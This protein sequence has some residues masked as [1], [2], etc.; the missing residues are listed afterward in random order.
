MFSNDPDRGLETLV[1]RAFVKV[2]IDISPEYVI[3]EGNE[4]QVLTQ[5]V[6]ITAQGE[7]PLK[8]EPMPFALAEKV[9]YRLEVIEPG[10]VF[11]ILF[12]N[13]PPSK[14]SFNGSLKIRTNYPE[15]P[16]ITIPLRAKFHSSSGSKKAF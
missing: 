13:T 14:G 11:N 1:I 16:V 6:T 8:L 9:T 10:K 15:K 5:I 7:K 3:F 4:G 12:K 2:P